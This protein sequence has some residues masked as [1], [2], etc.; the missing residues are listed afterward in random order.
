MPLTEDI[1]AEA[2]QRYFR[3]RDRYAK[4]AEA[5][6]H[7][8]RQVVDFRMVHAVI[9]S[10]VKTV[11]SF[12]G[13]L[14]RWMKNGSKDDEINSVDDVFRVM[15]D[16]AAVRVLTYL[17]EDREKVVEM[18]SQAFVNKQGNRL[19]SAPG[20]VERKPD[21]NDT[22]GKSSQ[23]YRATHC[24]VFLHEDECEG[25][26]ENLSGTPCEI[27]VCSLLAHVWNEIEHD[28]GYKPYGG[29]LSTDEKKY[30]QQLADLTVDGDVIIKQ[31]IA[32]SNAK[33]YELEGD[34]KNQQDFWFRLKE[35]I[36]FPADMSLVDE[37]YYEMIACGLK[38]PLDVQTKLLTGDY[39][40]RAQQL[41]RDFNQYCEEKELTIRLEVDEWLTV[42]FVSECWQQILKRA[43]KKVQK[44]H[45]RRI[46]TIAESMKRMLK[47]GK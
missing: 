29:E 23:N 32:A 18:F 30:L 12:N 43:D 5:V 22:S 8:V 40:K 16:L 38:S 37:T 25:V 15:G 10:R 7:R 31:L 20:D 24:R 2:V 14:L 13:K 28:I 44:A 45:P 39:H 47:G 34:F 41:I 3:E 42:L 21:P 26:H 9:Q 36:G 46:V 27:Q 35:L 4:L 17:E 33:A 1:R 19:R 6:E 11:E